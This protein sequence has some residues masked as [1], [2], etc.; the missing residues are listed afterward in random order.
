MGSILTEQPVEFIYIDRRSTKLNWFFKHQSFPLLEETQILIMNASQVLTAP[1]R[2]Q[3]FMHKT[4]TFGR[5]NNHTSWRF[6]KIWN[7]MN[8]IKIIKFGSLFQL[9]PRK[10]TFPIPKCPAFIQGSQFFLRSHAA[11]HSRPCDLDFTG[12]II[13]NEKIWG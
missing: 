7:I 12:W 3:D 11:S 1:V 2:L 5:Q 4:S 6:V 13:V 9:F 10:S 8:H